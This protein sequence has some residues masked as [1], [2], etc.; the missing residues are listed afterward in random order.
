MASTYMIANWKMNQSISEIDA[1]FEEFNKIDFE[2]QFIIAPQSIHIPKSLYLSKKAKIA[3][4]NISHKESGAFTGEVSSV[5]LKEMNI[6]YA[7]IGHSERRSI[8]GEDDKLINEKVATSLKNSITPI[9]CIGETLDQRE[10]DKTLDIVLGQIK[11]GLADIELKSKDSIILAYEPVWAIGTGK[12]ATSDEASAVHD[13]I[14]ELL[15]SNYPSFGKDI[16][17]L[18]GGSVKPENVTELLSKANIN[19]AL[20]GGASLKSESFAKLCKATL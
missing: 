16:S 8:F 10:A 11:A 4:Q 6:K 12:S 17:I 15:E 5:S 13:A 3:A 20:V 19:G 7:I 18:Y 2:G 14:R 9:L 1:F